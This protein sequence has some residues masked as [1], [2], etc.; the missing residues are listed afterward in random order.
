MSKV[1]EMWERVQEMFRQPSDLER[2][3]ASRHPTSAGD[4]DHLMRQ[5]NHK[6]Y[7]DIY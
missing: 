1:K 5:W 2:W 7:H 3:I 6:Q 4:L